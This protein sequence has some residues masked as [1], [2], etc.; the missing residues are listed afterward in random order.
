MYEWILYVDSTIHT[1]EVSIVKNAGL[2]TFICL[3]D[4]RKAPS[5]TVLPSW[6]NTMPVLVN[7]SKMLAY[8]GPSCMETLVNIELP[9]EFLKKMKRKQQQIF[10]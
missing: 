2:E 9:P 3:Q 5:T 8:R 6:L 4:I 7:A 10:S 1:R